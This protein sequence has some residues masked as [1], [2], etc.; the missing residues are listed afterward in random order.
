MTATCS[1]LDRG[2]WL[3]LSCE[4]L[5]RVPAG[6]KQCACTRC[7]AMIHARKSA[8]LTRSAALLAA[9]AMLYIPANMLPVISSGSLFGSQADT[10]LSG[11][12][13][14]WRTGSGLLA[15]VLFI[16]SVIVP[17]VK[18][19]TLGFLIW[20]AWRRW[21]WN[22]K[23]RALIYRATAY[24][25][26]WSMVDIYVGAVLVALV[27]FPLFAAVQP[28][29]GAIAFALVVV[30]TMLASMCFDP[31]LTWDSPEAAHG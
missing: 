4:Q 22:P 5:H 20:A 8:S 17:G 29:P 6:A 27:Q 16:A 2:L 1:A 12:M 3:C 31:R 11:V 24:I 19:A 30:L 10:I 13:H 26:R 7:G 18:L 9:A 23:Q 14:L 28:A 15:V 25:G 21:T